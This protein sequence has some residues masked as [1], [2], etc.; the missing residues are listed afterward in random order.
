MGQSTPIFSQYECRFLGSNL[1]PLETVA[2]TC[3]SDAAALEA[4]TLMFKQRV[5]REV[6]TGFEVWRDGNRLL[7]RLTT[8]E[9]ESWVFRQSAQAQAE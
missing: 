6:L 7:V 1:K 5:T 4:C 9:P 8:G 3:A 2:F